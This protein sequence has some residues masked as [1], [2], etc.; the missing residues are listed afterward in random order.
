MT[1]SNGPKSVMLQDET[2]WKGHLKLMIYLVK[3]GQIQKANTENQ[4]F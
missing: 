4:V 2:Q 3:L 1:S